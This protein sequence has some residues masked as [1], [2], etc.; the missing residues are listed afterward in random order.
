MPR[1]EPPRPPPSEDDEPSATMKWLWAALQVAGIPFPY[2]LRWWLTLLKSTLKWFMFTIV[3]ICMPVW[4]RHPLKVTVLATVV[5]VAAHWSSVCE[6]SRENF[7]ED[8][9]KCITEDIWTGHEWI[10]RWGNSI[11]ATILTTYNLWLR[12]VLAVWSK[13]KVWLSMAQGLVNE[14]LRA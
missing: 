8:I 3:L 4:E 10:F 5:G 14:K 1:G 11:A 7:E 2:L 12:G 13:T 9:E 6:V